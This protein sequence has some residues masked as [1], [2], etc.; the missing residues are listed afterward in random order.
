MV[1]SRGSSILGLFT[2]VYTLGLHCDTW[3]SHCD[4]VSSGGAQVLGTM[5]SVLWPTGSRV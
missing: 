1:G 4:G 3:A 5:G 2:F